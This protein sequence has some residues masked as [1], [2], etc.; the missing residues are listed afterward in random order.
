VYAIVDIETTG[1]KFNEEGITEIAIYKYDG[2]TIVDQFISLVNPEKP[3]QPFVVNLTGI[4]NKM[5]RD[6]PKFY[7]VAKRVVEI[8]ANCILV[9]HNTSFDYRI[10]RTEFDRVGYNFEMETLCTVELSKKLVPNLESYSL[11][12][13]CKTLGIAVADRHRASG[14]ALA[15]VKLLK[16]LMSKDAS[17]T[18]LKKNIKPIVNDKV[19]SEKLTQILAPLPKGIGIF[20]LHD[21]DG[22]ILYIGKST[23]IKK[24]VLKIFIGET[25]AK[26]ALQ[27]KVQSISTE[28]TGN[29]LISKIKYAQELLENNPKYNKKYYNPYKKYTIKLADMLIINKGRSLGEKSVIL[30]EDNTFKGYGYFDLNFQ[31]NSIEIVKNLINDTG[32][33]VLI[34]PIIDQ[35]LKRYK[36]EKIIYINKE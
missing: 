25:T 29:F 24:E 2:N 32:D 28:V 23:A 35:H 5:L 20:Y 19:V 7:E 8:M 26:I 36:S 4:T 14:D 10:L 21:A 27:K 18:I 17:K 34:L 3:I 6:A 12:K 9:A 15:T 30:I 22:N 16:L 1:G 11:G 33:S 13:L 31:I